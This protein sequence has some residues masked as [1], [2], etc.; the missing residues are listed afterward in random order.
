MMLQCDLVTGGNEH[1]ENN[2]AWAGYMCKD[3]IM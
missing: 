1:R 2:K 3:K